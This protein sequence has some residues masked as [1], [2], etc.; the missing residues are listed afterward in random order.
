MNV[1]FG[2]SDDTFDP[3]K[4]LYIK[5]VDAF[6]YTFHY[7][8]VNKNNEPF[9]VMHY[10]NESIEQNFKSNRDLRHLYCLC[11]IKNNKLKFYR[12]N[13]FEMINEDIINILDQKIKEYGK[14]NISSDNFVNKINKYLE[15][16]F[17]KLH[18]QHG[19]MIF[20]K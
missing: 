16:Q 10:T 20:F 1:F 5:P 12:T 15:Q 18:R 8:I 17:L 11:A 2:K 13:G 14:S 9:Y 7:T 19:T 6:H 4:S 3:N